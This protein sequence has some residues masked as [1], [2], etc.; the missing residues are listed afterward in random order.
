MGKYSTKEVKAALRKGRYIY[1]LFPDQNWIRIRDF[2]VKAGI[3]E[4]KSL[5]TETWKQITKLEERLQLLH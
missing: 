5:H 3:M 4:G 1:A 2:R